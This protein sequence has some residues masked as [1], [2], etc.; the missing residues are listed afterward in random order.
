MTLEEPEQAACVKNIQLF[1]QKSVKYTG[2]SRVVVA[3][4][5]AEYFIQFLAAFAKPA[6]FEFPRENVKVGRTAG[7]VT[8]KL[9]IYLFTRVLHYKC[10]NNLC[11]HSALVLHEQTC[12]AAPDTFGQH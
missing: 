2:R 3:T 4:W 9:A 7:G 12:I 6:D 1:E 8:S 5:L 11:V 10:I